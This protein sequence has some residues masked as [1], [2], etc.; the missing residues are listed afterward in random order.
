MYRTVGHLIRRSYKW[1]KRDFF[2]YLYKINKIFFNTLPI[3]DLIII[4]IPNR[5]T[6]S[7]NYSFEP[8]V[9][10]ILQNLT[11]PTEAIGLMCA[12]VLMAEKIIKIIVPF[13]SS[14]KIISNKKILYSLPPGC[15]GLHTRGSWCFGLWSRTSS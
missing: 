1:F 12:E 13:K 8:L 10:D 9:E 5:Y 4:Y 2:F 6:S 14:T 3:T 7:S 11:V 15:A